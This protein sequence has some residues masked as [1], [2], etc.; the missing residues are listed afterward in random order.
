MSTGCG[1]APATL[2]FNSRPVSP[3]GHVRRKQGRCRGGRTLDQLR[4]GL[5]TSTEIGGDLG[6]TGEVGE[7][8]TSSNGGL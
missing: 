6:R 3:N 2:L 8:S 1:G 4:P 7:G 5:L